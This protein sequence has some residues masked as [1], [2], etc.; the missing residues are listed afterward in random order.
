MKKTE[1]I[2]GI[3]A[4]QAILDNAPE[5]VFELY[6]HEK[7]EDARL[8]DLF[9]SAKRHHIPLKKLPMKEFDRLLPNTTHQGVIASCSERES[10]S[11]KE[12]L[13][14]I[15]NADQPL[16]LILDGVTD[17]HNLGAC[18]RNANAAGALA[19]IIP[20]DNSASLT[21]V[22]IKAASG[23]AELTPLVVVT[24]VARTMRNLK[25][26][27]LWCYGLD[28]TASDSIYTTDLSGPAVL[29]LGAEGKG[30]RRLTAE[31]CDALINIPMSGS[32][33][34]LNVSVAT[35]ICL[36]EA[37]RQRLTSSPS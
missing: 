25:E 10:L 14:M 32:V 6:I 13:L 17:P 1:L 27:G 20:K 35:G 37:N 33:E 22:A 26:A 23:A 4:V 31:H 18:I 7:R 36:F 34:S 8:Q 2:F 30:L 11:E 15:K 3:H 16:L 21:P 5:R 29:V 19:V 24:N 9:A 12:L 28:A